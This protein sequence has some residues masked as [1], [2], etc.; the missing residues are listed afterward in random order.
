MEKLPLKLVQ[1]G[2]TLIKE[3]IKTLERLEVVE[4]YGEV[5]FYRKNYAPGFYSREWSFIDD[6]IKFGYKIL[7][8]E[9]QNEE[10][11]EESN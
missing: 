1:K 6:L 3:N 9:Q 5:V 10:K 2:D 7:N 11:N 8:L 4:V